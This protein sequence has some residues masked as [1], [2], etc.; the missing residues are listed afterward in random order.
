LTFIVPNK[1]HPILTGET[2]ARKKLQ[3]T[4]DQLTQDSPTM[5]DLIGQLKDQGI[6]VATETA[7]TIQRPR[8]SGD[9]EG[10]Q[11]ETKLHQG[12][13]QAAQNRDYSQTNPD[14]QAQQFDRLRQPTIQTQNQESDTQNEKEKRM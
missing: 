11:R 9:T 3:D 7:S 12:E 10:D 2:S 8:R 1:V 4:I 14:T 6:D 5:P 13:S